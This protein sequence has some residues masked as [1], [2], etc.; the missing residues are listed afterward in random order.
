MAKVYFKTLFFRFFFYC[1]QFYFHFKYTYI[2]TSFPRIIAG[3]SHRRED[4]FW[5]LSFINFKEMRMTLKYKYIEVSGN[6]GTELLSQFAVF[7]LQ[8]RIIWPG[9]YWSW[10]GRSEKNFIASLSSL[11][12]Q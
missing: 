9:I 2:S 8:F 5:C 11:S 3:G 10:W 7:L 4:T 12:D 6:I 1:H